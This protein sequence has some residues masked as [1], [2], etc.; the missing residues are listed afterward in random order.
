MTKKT[1]FFVVIVSILS[2]FAAT[3]A[4][5][6]AGAT[7]TG[8]EPPAARAHESG[9]FIGPTFS[10]AYVIPEDLH[11]TAGLAAAYFFGHTFGW[12]GTLEG[13]YRLGARNAQARVTAHYWYYL[14]RLGITAAGDLTPD[15]DDHQVVYIGPDIQVLFPVTINLGYVG[16]L[17]LCPFYRF[18]YPLGNSGA[19]FVQMVGL[20]INPL[21]EL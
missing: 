2:A 5:E 7:T 17:A 6:T 16:F 9:V 3:A 11:L 4:G 10:G 21:F 1:S 12:D 20:S 8:E 18:D 15:R 19:E 14:L 13:G